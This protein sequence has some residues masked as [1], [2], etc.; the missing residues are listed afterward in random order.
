MLL[1]LRF[2]SKIDLP[3]WGPYISLQCASCHS[4]F[5]AVLKIFVPVTYGFIEFWWLQ[6]GVY[7]YMRPL[8]NEAPHSDCAS[9]RQTHCGEAF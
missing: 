7:M 8:Q 1:V 4:G 2:D 6:G 9:R 5:Y 3:K